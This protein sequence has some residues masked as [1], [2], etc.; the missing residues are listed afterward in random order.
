MDNVQ[1]IEK[2][3]DAA[4]DLQK[5]LKVKLGDGLQTMKAVQERVEEYNMYSNTFTS[6]VYEHLRTSIESQVLT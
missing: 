4:G 3:Q 5:V 1:D 6:R 2:I